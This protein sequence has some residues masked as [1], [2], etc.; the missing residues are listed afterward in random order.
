[1]TIPVK[2]IPIAKRA[3]DILLSGGMLTDGAA[4]GRPGRHHQARRR[5]H[6]VLRTEP[7]S[8]KVDASFAR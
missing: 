1:M 2:G 5:R 8:V 6:R 4:L 7:L 3:L